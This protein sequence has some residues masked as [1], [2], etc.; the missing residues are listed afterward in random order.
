M[1]EPIVTEATH[2]GSTFAYVLMGLILVF[3]VIAL[4][5]SVFNAEW[6]GIA[7][8]AFVAVILGGMILAV[9]SNFISWLQGFNS[10]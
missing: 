5:A 10:F 7:L 3:G 6:K 2:A 1:M 4:L 9:G 8:K